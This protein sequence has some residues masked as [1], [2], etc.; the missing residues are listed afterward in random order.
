M[1]LIKLQTLLMLILHLR[2]LMKYHLCYLSLSYG[3]FERCL[4]QPE[5]F[6]LWGNIW[7]SIKVQN[8]MKKKWNEKKW[9]EMKWVV[10]WCNSES[11]LYF[12]TWI[13]YALCHYVFVHFP[14][15]GFFTIDFAWFASWCCRGSY[16]LWEFL[17][18]CW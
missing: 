18:E 5:I 8:E 3:V 2:F 9:N 15:C 13:W 12:V 17:P 1:S 16:M 7:N 10:V 6:G 11:L 14:F 4:E